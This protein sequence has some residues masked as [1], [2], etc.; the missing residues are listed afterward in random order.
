MCSSDLKADKNES[1]QDINSETIVALNEVSELLDIEN[2]SIGDDSETDKLGDDE[3]NIEKNWSRY[4]LSKKSGAPEST[5]NNIYNRGSIPSVI[6]LE[7]LC[8]AFDI[9]LSQF[10]CT[11]ENTTL[12]TQQLVL[13]KKWDKISKNHQRIILELIDSLY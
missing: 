2:T 4:E 9:S 12:T 1:V 10:F 13:L 3:L 6:T 7:S 8:N 5:I 11:E